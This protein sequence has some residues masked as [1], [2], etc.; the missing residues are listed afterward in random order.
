M[1]E[2]AADVFPNELGRVVI[3]VSWALKDEKE[4][5]DELCNQFLVKQLVELTTVIR[6]LQD[7]WH[8]CEFKHRVFLLV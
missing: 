7:Y 6:A 1:F 2:L 4:C 3:V 8:E 5:L